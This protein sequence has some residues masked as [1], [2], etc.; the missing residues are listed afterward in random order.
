[1][2]KF[3]AMAGLRQ[4]L[5]PVGWNL[6]DGLERTRRIEICLLVPGEAVHNPGPI[7]IRSLMPV[8]FR[9][10]TNT[11]PVCPRIIMSAPVEVI[12][13]AADVQFEPF[14]QRYLVLP[15]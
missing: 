1:M 2:A 11:L 9:S 10:T 5:V 14:C 7:G 4:Q 12:E 8:L 13:P 6:R 3:K 15:V